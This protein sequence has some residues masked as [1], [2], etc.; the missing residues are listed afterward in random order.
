MPDGTR[1]SALSVRPAS[2]RAPLATLFQFTI[3]ADPDLL[4]G[5]AT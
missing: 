2:A 5:D 1:I 4:L 3:Y